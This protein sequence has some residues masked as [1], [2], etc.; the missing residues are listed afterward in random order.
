MPPVILPRSEHPISRKQIDPDALK[1]LYRLKQ[2]GHVA[3]LVGGGVRDLLLGLRPKDFDISTSAHP[4]EVRR[5]FRNCRLIGRRFRLAHI[6]FAGGKVIEVATFRRQSEEARADGEDLL[7]RRENT[8][9]TPEEDAERRDFTINALFYDIATFSVI[10]YVGGLRDLADRVVRTIGDPAVRLREDPIRMLRAVK[11]ASRLDLDIAAE[12]MQAM[13]LYGADL[14]RAAPERLLL[15]VTRMLA[16]GSAVS[17]TRW[18]ERTGLLAA[19]LPELERYLDEQ[20]RLG[21]GADRQLWD[22]LAGLD[23]WVRRRRDRGEPGDPAVST[24]LAVPL[25]AVLEAP[26]LARDQT[27]RRLLRR[28][29]GFASS[30]AADEAVPGEDERPLP[31]MADDASAA[32]SA[33]SRPGLTASDLQAREAWLTPLLGRLAV[34]R[35]EAEQLLHVLAAQ[36][37]LQ[38]PPQRPT[39]QRALA[40]RP[41]FLPA[42]DVHEALVLGGLGSAQVLKRWQDVAV[43]GGDQEQGPDGGTAARRRRRRPR[44]VAPAPPGEVL[45]DGAPPPDDPDA[46][47]VDDERLAEDEQESALRRK[48]EAEQKR[49]E[50]AY[51]QPRYL[52]SHVASSGRP[53][54]RQQAEPGAEASSSPGGRRRR[55][56]R[57]RGGR[58]TDAG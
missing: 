17:A 34:P 53:R 39:S 14:L 7:V 57:R 16:S 25:A 43:R 51:D 19:L 1:V 18:L 55:R 15:E 4:N 11:F 21:P 46:A 23:R 33:V 41:Y 32:A 35:R 40:H 20:R 9:G 26:T 10:D 30:L 22:A 3:Y 12:D 5:L 29:M 44:R 48:A 6:L 13:R 31:A 24:L 56:R 28:G 27:S 37:Q 50:S 47:A 49:R 8:F 38:A 42:L 45:A 54:V 58:P 2:A 52:F 36:R